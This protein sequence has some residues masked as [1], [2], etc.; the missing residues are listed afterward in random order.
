MTNLRSSLLLRSVA[1]L[2]L[3]FFMNQAQAQVQ[4]A[5]YVSM[6]PNTNGYYEYLPQGYNNNPGQTYPLI[7]FI[8]G[9]GELGNGSQWDLPRLLYTGLAASINVGELPVS[10]NVNGQSHSFIVISPQ[11]INWPN[12]NDIDGIL[13]YV[14]SHY[15]VNT[16]R[17]Y[18]TGLSMGGGVVWDYVG[19]SSAN[20]NRVAAIVPICGA[21]WPE[22]NRA[23]TIANANVAVW[24][25]H[26]TH[27]PTVPVGYT[28]DYI[29]TINQS[30]SP[31]PM[32]KK[33][34][35]D[36]WSHDA[37]TLTY[38]STYR[39][40]YGKTIYEWMLQYARGSAP[41]PGNQVPVANAGADQNTGSTAQLNGSAW[42]PDGSIASYNWTKVSGPDSYSFSNASS[43]STSVNNLGSGTYTFRLTVTD[44]AGASASDDVVIQVS[45]PT[46]I[47]GKVEAEN[48][49]SMSGIQTENSSEGGQNVA[50]QDN[51][52]WMDYTVNV[53]NSGTYNVQFRVATMFNGPQFQLKKSDGNVLA[54]VNVPNTGWFQSWQT[55]S[56]S[57]YL[58]AGTQ[59]LRIYTTNAA[60]GW[61]FN[62][63]NFEQAA[64][65]QTPT[66]NA[67]SSQTI[68]LPTNSVNLSG[69]AWDADGSISTHHWTQVSGPSSASFSNEWGASTSAQALV[70]GSYVFR[71]NVT[72]NAGATASSDVTVTVNGSSSGGGSS[73]SRI[74][75]EQFSSM[76]GIQV[77]NTSDDGGGQ[78]VA[79][80][81]DNDWMDYTVNVSS[82]GTYTI[83][84]RVATM[85]NGPQFQLRN[86]NGGVL[87]TVNVPNTGWFQT[88][89]TVSAQVTLPA[90]QQTL[91]IYTTSASGGWNINWWEIQ[92]ASSGT[93]P[94]TPSSS[95]KIEAEQYTSMS[96]IQTE[97]TSDAGG[98]QNV[99]WQDENDW[100]DY[101]VNLSSAGMYTINF[102]VATMFNGPQFQLRNANGSVLATVNVPNT[103]WFQ[104]WQ[105][106]SVQVSLPA[107][108]QTLRIVTTNAAGGWNINWWEIT[109]GSTS[110]AAVNTAEI[111]TP[112]SSK[113]LEVFPNPVKD[114]F[115]MKVNNDLT[116]SMQVQVYNM[117]GGLLK[118]FKLNK[119]NKGVSQSYLSIGTLPAGE[120]VM[121]VSMGQWRESR[122]IIRQ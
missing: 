117:S 82:A 85:F 10:L 102:R 57:V 16:S 75:A 5:K 116:G 81:D 121:I 34:I 26:N 84:F 47:P 46:N 19:A 15:R 17:I 9:V 40:E 76:N 6:G 2:I 33:S 69:S 37:W 74:E 70:Q 101:S 87:A 119:Q 72:D 50:W 13:N 105:T 103:G 89:Q 35:Y 65:N 97:N 36:V 12:P 30:P 27:D 28:N 66:V 29:S 106:V 22:Y 61:N 31:N 39:D 90:G 98:G 95:T 93:Q 53:S 80:Q 14:T 91:R 45:S 8:H 3:T 113:A 55:V 118:Q 64:S 42:D 96:G 4:T 56:A 23:R 115:M 100:M 38:N 48:Y 88:W 59:T 114:R 112:S 92:G 11:F 104:T 7:L 108:Q 83:N 52:D 94:S 44:N 67:G 58:S 79:W 99:G 68:T 122:K 63:M 25:H 62:W 107:G 21:S 77:E 73:S 24:A 120:Y 54:T 60:G 78:N 32:A 71:L 110:T 18:L 1:I 51:G 111:V 109:S 41:P 86:S 43:V 20:A 49:A